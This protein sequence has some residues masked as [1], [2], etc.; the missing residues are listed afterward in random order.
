MSCRQLY[1]IPGN[2]TT[3]GAGCQL[4]KD[5]TLNKGPVLGV[6]IYLSQGINNRTRIN[7]V[8]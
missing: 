4:L 7:Q 2:D 5:T 3:Q 6:I 1:Q 8:V